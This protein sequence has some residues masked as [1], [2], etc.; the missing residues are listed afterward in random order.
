MNLI[1]LR[2]SKKIAIFPKKIPADTFLQVLLVYKTKSKGRGETGGGL[3]GK[4]KSISV[5]ETTKLSPAVSL[6]YYVR[7]KKIYTIY[8]LNLIN[9]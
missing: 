6:C 9:F 5:L 2:F 8:P 7:E 1:L 4:S 3:M